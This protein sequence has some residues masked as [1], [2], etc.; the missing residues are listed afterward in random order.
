MNKI[1]QRHGVL[2]VIYDLRQLSNLPE[3]KNRCCQFKRESE[4]WFAVQYAE[5]SP[6]SLASH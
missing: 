6:T 3:S 2:Y 5:V 4:L 1:Q